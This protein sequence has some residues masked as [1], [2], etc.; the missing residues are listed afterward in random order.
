MTTN[1]KVVTNGMYV[2]TVKHNGKEVGTVGPGSMVE[3]S[4]Y[5]PHGQGPQLYEIDERPATPEE[6]EA[7]KAAQT[8][9]QA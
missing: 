5:F 1:V 3:K 6:I 4:F 2:A 8:A 7:Y 9:P